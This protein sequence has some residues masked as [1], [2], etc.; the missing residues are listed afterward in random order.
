M[1]K[2]GEA[3]PEVKLSWA[4]IATLIHTD[5][6]VRDTD[7]IATIIAG[8]LL[9]HIITRLLHIICMLIPALRKD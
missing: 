4:H 2:R 6:N 1:G 3:D 9:K 8:E 5:T 7:S